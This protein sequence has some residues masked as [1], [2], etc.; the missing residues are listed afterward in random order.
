MARTGFRRNIVQARIPIRIENQLTRFNYHNSA[1]STSLG[2][3][4]IE[5]GHCAHQV[6]H[7]HTSPHKVWTDQ[8]S[9]IEPYMV[10]VIENGAIPGG[11]TM[12][13]RVKIATTFAYIRR[14]PIVTG[15]SKSHQDH[16]THS[17]QLQPD[18]TTRC[19]CILKKTSQL[20]W[21]ITDPECVKLDLQVT[22]LL[23][24]YFLQFWAV[25]DIRSVTSPFAIFSLKNIFSRCEYF[26]EFVNTI[27]TWK[28]WNVKIMHAWL[29][30]L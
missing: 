7:A 4:F 15:H 16:R 14:G 12:K 5:Y 19:L 6:S 1:I 13:S 18:R 27:E 25:L 2:R 10:W 9:Y 30:I 22:T 8:V 29:F 17:D 3:R 21:L 26:C 23:A 28:N 11:E 20:S 24:L